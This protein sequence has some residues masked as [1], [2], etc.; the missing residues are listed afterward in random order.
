LSRD[1]LAEKSGRLLV[2]QV[3]KNLVLRWHFLFREQKL[4]LFLLVLF[5]IISA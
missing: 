1:K 4:H 3:L 5:R 2:E